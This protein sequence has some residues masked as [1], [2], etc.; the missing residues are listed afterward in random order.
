MFTLRTKSKRKGRRYLRTVISDFDGAALMDDYDN[1][2][3]NIWIP[4]HMFVFSYDLASKALLI[5]TQTT[6]QRNGNHGVPNRFFWMCTKMFL[7]CPNKAF[8]SCESLLSKR[9]SCHLILSRC[10]TLRHP[11]IISLPLAS[12]G[13]DA[14]SPVMEA[15]PHQS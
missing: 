5:L 2:V 15:P 7:I 9:F 14:S 13:G 1:N 4:R 8:V 11:D 3:Y 12:V 10:E 6:F